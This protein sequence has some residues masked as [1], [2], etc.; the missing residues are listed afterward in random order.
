[1]LERALD[2]AARVLRPGAR[3]LVLADPQQAARIPVVRWSALA[4]HHDLSLVLL[5]DPLELQPPSAALQFQTAQQ[6]IGLDLRR[7]EVQ[8]HWQA[9][10]VE[11]LQALR[12]QLGARRV[13]VQVLSTDA[14]S[15][16]WLAPPVTEVPA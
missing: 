4:Q 15:D 1:G 11:P 16:A 14:P 9:H 5:V 6:R 13:D 10:F 7:S 12:R 2:H 8:A 3:M